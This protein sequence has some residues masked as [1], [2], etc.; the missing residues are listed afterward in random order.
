M[1]SIEHAYAAIVRNSEKANWKL[2]EVLP[3]GTKL[4]FTRPFLPD[5]LAYTNGISCL[6]ARERMVLNQIA[7]NSYLNL[8]AFVE[9]YILATVVHHAQAEDVDADAPSAIWHWGAP[10][11]V[12]AQP[13]P[14]RSPSRRSLVR[15][16]RRRVR[17]SR[18]PRRSLARRSTRPSRWRC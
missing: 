13:K 7:G 12:P 11:I 17:C 9:E 6:D 3:V 5:A 8:F 14:S 2:D 15:R 4:D 16:Q 10:K 1:L 18:N